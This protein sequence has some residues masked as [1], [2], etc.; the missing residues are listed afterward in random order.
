MEF[1]Q[2]PDKSQTLPVAGPGKDEFSTM[3]EIILAGLGGKNNIMLLDNCITRLRID[4]RDNSLV[5]EQKIKSAGISGIIRSGK[6]SIQVVIGTNVQFVADA[7][8]KML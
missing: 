5:D 3:A 7:M 6:S 4:I 8:K 2:R 1:F